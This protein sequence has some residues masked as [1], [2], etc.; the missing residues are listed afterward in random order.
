MTQALWAAAAA[1][2]TRL[3]VV[4]KGGCSVP[5]PGPKAGAESQADSQWGR[6]PRLVGSDRVPP[7]QEPPSPAAWQAGALATLVLVWVSAEDILHS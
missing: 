5:K 4:G 3:L 2:G 6:F 1:P 7:A